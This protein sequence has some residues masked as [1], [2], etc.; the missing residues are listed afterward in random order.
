MTETILNLIWLVITLAGVWLWR[1][2]WHASRRDKRGRVTM[3]LVAV[4]CVLALL[5]PVI[6]LTDDLHPEIMVADAAW[7]TESS[8]PYWKQNACARG[9]AQD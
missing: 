1:F 6:S 3:E 7:E 5:F 2:R 9:S 4:V 8:S